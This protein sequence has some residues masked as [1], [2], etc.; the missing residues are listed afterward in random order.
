MRSG[1]DPRKESERLLKF[2]FNAGILI[3]E[4]FASRDWAAIGKELDAIIGGFVKDFIRPE[5]YGIKVN[6]LVTN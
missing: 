6:E 1:A 3:L 4:F 5:L 2:K